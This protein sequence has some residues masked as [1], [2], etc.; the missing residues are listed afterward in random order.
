MKTKILVSVFLMTTTFCAY[1]TDEN[2]KPKEE[3][4]LTVEEKRKIDL[5]RLNLYFKK[6][7]LEWEEEKARVAKDEAEL[8]KEN[9]KRTSEFEQ[10]RTAEQVKVFED[11]LDEFKHGQERN[12]TYLNTRHNME[13]TELYTDIARKEMVKLSNLDQLTHAQLK[14]FKLIV[15]FANEYGNTE[16]YNLPK[17]V[18]RVE[19]IFPEYRSK[20][21]MLVSNYGKEKNS[22][23]AYVKNYGTVLKLTP[24]EIETILHNPPKIIN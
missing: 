5:K 14:L 1:S 22:E 19:Q 4:K 11:M 24:E 7:G 3:K 6:E 15:T 2:I 13:R 8:E 21:Q 23:R 20:L 10:M 9:A 12:P 17:V 18:I 16:F